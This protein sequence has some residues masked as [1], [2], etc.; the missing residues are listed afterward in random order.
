MEFRTVLQA[1]WCGLVTSWGG[2]GASRTILKQSWNGHGTVLEWSWRILGL[3][4]ALLECLGPSWYGLGAM[5]GLSS[6]ILKCL[7]AVLGRLEIVLGRSWDGLGASWNVSERSW[8]ILCRFWDRLGMVW[9]RDD[10]NKN[11][12]ALDSSTLRGRNLRGNFV[13]ILEELACNTLGCRT[14]K[15]APNSLP[16]CCSPQE[17]TTC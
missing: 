10:V 8:E 5:L 17:R 4:G 7:G 1:S 11:L 6:G 16:I 15:Q 12:S 3:L 2:R 13:K 9:E 14:S